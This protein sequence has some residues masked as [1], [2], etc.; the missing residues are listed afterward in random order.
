MTDVHRSSNFWASVLRSGTTRVV[1]MS[2]CMLIMASLMESMV[3]KL[4]IDI[5]GRKVCM[6][7]ELSREG[8]FLTFR[9]GGKE[10]IGFD[11]ALIRSVRQCTQ[12]T[13]NVSHAEG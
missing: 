5:D 10:W 7:E 8:R 6:E 1:V 12:R 9:V 3:L 2:S 11:E 4:R 13:D